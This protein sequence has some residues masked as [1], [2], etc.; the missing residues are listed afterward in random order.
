MKIIVASKKQNIIKPVIA[1]ML[2]WEKESGK[3][4][5]SNINLQFKYIDW[6]TFVKTSLNH[7]NLV[8]GLYNIDTDY[9][10]NGIIKIL[11]SFENIIVSFADE[12]IKKEFENI[13]DG[14]IEISQN[15]DWIYFE[16]INHE[17]LKGTIELKPLH[18]IYFEN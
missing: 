1:L 8:I 16:S 2:L 11:E 12:K 4:I 10:I 3:T 13:V 17:F 18:S 6:E 14:K 5:I 9:N 15:K 7:K